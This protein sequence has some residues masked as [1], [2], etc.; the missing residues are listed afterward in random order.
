MTILDEI[1]EHKRQEV[2]ASKRRVSSNS[3]AERAS[4]CRET[5]RGFRQALTARPGVRVIAEI[6]RRSPSKGE[7][8][9]DLDPVDCARSYA[10]AGAAAIS[11]LTDERYFGGA[12]DDVRI[13]DSE[14]N[15][16]AVGDLYNAGPLYVPE[17]ST[18]ALFSLG[19]L[20]LLGWGRHRRR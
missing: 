16:T 7:I 12:V 20:G 19:L 2:A 9:P 17:P 11:V 10:G 5:I 15:A 13:Y 14:L 18:I 8:R 1:L 3:M 6:K 4:G